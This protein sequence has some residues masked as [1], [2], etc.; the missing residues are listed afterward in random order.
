MMPLPYLVKTDIDLS[1]DLDI[2]VRGIC[3]SSG[4]GLT[5]D[6]QTEVIE[7]IKAYYQSL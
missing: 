5:E 2:F 3:L 1:G 6:Q 4:T 7:A